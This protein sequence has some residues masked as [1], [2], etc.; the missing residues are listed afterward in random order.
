MKSNGG[1]GL[2]SL[3]GLRVVELGVWVAAP[4]VAA[5]L[6][7]WGADVVKVEPPT[8]DPM[9]WVFGSIGVGKDR[10]NPAFTLDNRG[11]RSVVLDLREPTDRGHLERL[12]KEAD[13]FVSNL[14]PDALDR[15]GLEPE[16]TVERHPHLVYCA[17]SGYGLRGEDRDR[18]SYDLGAFWARSGLSSQLAG[19]DGV[20]LNARGAIGDHITGLAA[21][22]GTLAAIL[23]Q[24]HTGRGQVVEASLLRTGAYVS[25]WD[26]SL[27]LGFGKVAGAEPRH[28]NQ[29]PLMNSYRTKDG[30]WFFLTGVETERHLPAVCRAVDRPDLLDDPRFADA[31]S[32]RRNCS[33]FISI[34]DEVIGGRTLDEW[35]Q[36]FER[37]G[38]WWAPVRAPAEVIADPQFLANDGLVEVG[39]GAA[40]SAERSINGPVGFSDVT[41]RF[42]TAPTLG[43]HTTEV[44]EGLNSGRGRES[45]RGPVNP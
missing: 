34:L 19:S 37:E 16:A 31:A 42:G 28:Q 40:E 8:G 22:A 17:I 39:D 45:R 32:V 7:D 20:P 5:L 6:A 27:Q 36:A 33:E 26:L 3:A 41:R 38:V 21:L 13:V 11:K 4:A 35:S 9:R 30:R 29:A 15:L 18:P 1:R 14:R 24:R 10:P 2:S 25:G 43:Q 44:L 12:L 23:E